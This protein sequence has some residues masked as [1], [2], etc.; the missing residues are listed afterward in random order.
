MKP[1]TQQ[2]RKVVTRVMN[3]ERVL[4]KKEI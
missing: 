1:E 3:V 2:S 4:P